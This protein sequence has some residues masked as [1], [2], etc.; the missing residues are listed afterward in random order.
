MS[1][2]SAVAFPVVGSTELEAAAAMLT[3]SGLFQVIRLFE[4]N[5][6]FRELPPEGDIG[7]AVVLD[8]ETTGVDSQTAGLLELGMVS[9]AYDRQTGEVLTALQVFDELEDPGIP[10]PSE[11]SEVNHIT[12]EMVKGKRID[13]KAVLA[14]VEQAD[15]IIAH[16]AIFDRQVCEKRFPFFKGKA[17]ACSLTQVPWAA[18]GYVSSKL[19][20]I[21]YKMG[22]FYAAHR[23]DTDCLALLHVLEMPVEKLEGKTV[24]SA[25][26]TQYNAIAR[27]IWATGASYDVKDTLKARGYRWSDGTKPGTEKAWWIEVPD[28]QFED[29]LNWLRTAAF[30]D[31]P[32]SVPVDNIT[33][34]NRFSDRQ[35]ERERVYR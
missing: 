5:T 24:L 2:N 30:H 21:A 14:F 32:F 7:I 13:D 3:H 18:L 22:F 35:G 15:F 19:E 20:F 12:D 6:L 31:R 4:A 9:F 27:R 26:L 8:T 29:E 17:W 33:A 1:Q 16:N 11:A 23:A 28:A 25:M 34:F 10:I